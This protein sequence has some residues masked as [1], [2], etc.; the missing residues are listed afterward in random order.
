MDVLRPSPTPFLTPA[1][2]FSLFCTPCSWNVCFY[3]LWISLFQHTPKRSAHSWKCTVK[4][5]SRDIL[6]LMPS[7]PAY[8]KVT[9][10]LFALFLVIADLIT[11]LL[12]IICLISLLVRVH[13]HQIL[14][15]YANCTMCIPVPLLPAKPKWLKAKLCVWEGGC[16]GVEV[17]TFVFTL[18]LCPTLKSQCLF[19]F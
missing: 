17:V 7:I 1:L 18:F 11:G 4:L 3:E 2:G 19:I 12:L 5:R 9:I 15:Y 8:A 14:T 16:R 10:C 13:S 6:A